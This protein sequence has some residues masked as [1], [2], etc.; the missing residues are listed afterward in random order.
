MGGWG[1]SHS[2]YKTNFNSQ[3]DLRRTSQL[4]LSL[5]ILG[6]T[7]T[8]FQKSRVIPSDRWVIP[9]PCDRRK[10]SQLLLLL[11]EVELG[12]QVG[13][14]FD[15]IESTTGRDNW[16]WLNNLMCQSDRDL[17]IISFS[18]GY[19]EL[20]FKWLSNSLHELLL[21]VEGGATCQGFHSILFAPDSGDENT[22]KYSYLRLNSYPRHN[23]SAELWCYTV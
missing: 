21:F 14:Q 22:Y 23:S 7:L 18:K 1:G 4:E 13:E 8:K 10:Q 11:T 16:D 9:S 6:K 19:W 15:K 3:L 20:N 5:A 17:I 12:L 2:D